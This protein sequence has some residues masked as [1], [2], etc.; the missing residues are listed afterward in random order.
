MFGVRRLRGREA[1]AL[2]SPPEG[3]TTNVCPLTSWRSCI[4]PSTIT[5]RSRS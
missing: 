3:G 1:H 4:T 2:C 5:S